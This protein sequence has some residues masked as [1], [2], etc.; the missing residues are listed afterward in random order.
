MEEADFARRVVP[1]PRDVWQSLP[2]TCLVRMFEFG[3]VRQEYERSYGREPDAAQRD[4]SQR[5]ALEDIVELAMIN[6]REYQTQKEILYNFALSLT[7]ERFDYDLKFATSDNRTAA[8][9]L[10]NR[11]GGATVN[12]LSVPTTVTGNKLLATGGDVLARFANE[13]VLTF[14]GA[15]GFAADIGS[16]LLLDISQSVFQRDF[17]FENLTQ[18]ERKVVYAAR[19]FARFR[20]ELFANLAGEYYSLLLAYRG[21]EIETQTYFSNLRQYLQG[22][23]EY[24]AGRLP[25]LQVDQ[26]EQTALSSRSSLIRQCNSLER[27]LDGLKLSIG[28]PPE[29][30]LNLELTELEELTLRDEATVLGER[31]GRAR[32]ELL[33]QR[34]EPAPD[35]GVL[36]NA[37][38]DLTDKMLQLL[39]LHSQLGQPQLDVESL[40]LLLARLSVDEARMLSRS[41]REFLQQELQA[42]P[43]PPP[44]RIFRRTTDLADSLLELTKLHLELAAKMPVDLAIVENIRRRRGELATRFAQ[45]G[46]EVADA[47]AN[48][49]LDRMAQLNL[50][51]KTLLKDAEA[52]AREGDGVT[53]AVLRPPEEELQETLDTVQRLLAES[54]QLLEAGAGGLTP[55]ELEMDDAMLTGL[56]RRFD[57][58]NERGKLADTW[59]QIK[60]RGDDLKSVLNLSAQQRIRTRSNR[61]FGFTF[62]ESQ[63]RL[64][65]TLDTPLNRK[66]QRNNFRRSLIDY[67]AGLRNLMQLEDGIKLSVRDDLRELQLRREQYQIAVASA[68][69]ASERVVSTR[70]MMQLGLEDVTARDFVEAQQDYTRSLNDV[71]KEHIGY[72]LDRIQLFLDLELLEVDDGGFWP[73]LYNERYQ[74]DPHYQLPP[75]ARPAYGTLPHGVCY[76]HKMKRMLEIPTGRTEVHSDLPNRLQGRPPV[77]EEVPAPLPQ[78]P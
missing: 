47:I 75:Y 72:I 30:P 45:I 42:V 52:L 63:T 78:G 50:T 9:Y 7:L 66:L 48:Q 28:L 51:A 43:L 36:L 6:S 41:N 68:A 3:S 2:S 60:L 23:A 71:A 58:M 74:P 44:V 70:L 38:M 53:Q 18:A 8:D 73:E 65:L 29:L 67:Q 46:N 13:V 26:I 39:E 32:R 35:R 69:L 55:I 34:S 20:K 37:A 24:R 10:H 22:E 77:P 76:S 40:E 57:L 27:S 56:V 31:V 59:R 64:A 33:S 49:Q 25:R 1:V 62:D 11:S 14:N 5:L 17:V 61:P 15:D 54:Q 19:D 12:G 16:E 21:I 4:S